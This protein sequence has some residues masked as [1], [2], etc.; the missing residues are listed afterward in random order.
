MSYSEPGNPAHTLTYSVSE[1]CFNVSLFLVYDNVS[2]AIFSSQVF[3]QCSERSQRRVAEMF[4][5]TS[6]CQYVC[7]FVCNSESQNRRGVRFRT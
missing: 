6:L 3:D 4:I 7:P 2:K 5:L 1:I